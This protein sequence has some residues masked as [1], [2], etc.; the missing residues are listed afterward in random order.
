MRT[1]R[2]RT[3]SNIK[4]RPQARR[5]GGPT[6]ADRHRN[7]EVVASPYEPV[8]LIGDYGH[9]RHRAFSSGPEHVPCGVPVWRS[10]SIVTTLSAQ[11]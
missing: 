2:C 11:E 4:A 3:K 8:H 7:I 9:L 10:R 1:T 5:L 6:P